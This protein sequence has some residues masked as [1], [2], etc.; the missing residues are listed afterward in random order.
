[1]FIL[2]VHLLSTFKVF[3]LHEYPIYFNGTGN[4]NEYFRQDK[5]SLVSVVKD[6]EIFLFGRVCIMKRHDDDD[7]SN[8]NNNNNNTFFNLLHG[9]ESFLR[10]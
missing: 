10:S 8:N 7:D 9:A 3:D 1:M 2:T 5:E 6:T 4:C